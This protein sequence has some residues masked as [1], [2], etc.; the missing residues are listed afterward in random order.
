VKSRTPT[1]QTP[2]IK[3]ERYFEEFY[4]SAPNMFVSVCAKTGKVVQ[5]NAS[6]VT[7][8]GYPKQEIIG[9]SIL[10]RFTPKTIKKTQATYE[11]FQKNGY[12]ENAELILRKKNGGNIPVLVNSK[13][14]RDKE[15]KILYSCS[16]LTDISKLQND[17]ANIQI[18]VNQQKSAK[19][20]LQREKD[21]LQATIDC[22]GE[23]VIITNKQ[24]DFTHF[25][26][27]AE[28]L[29]GIGNSGTTI[30]QWSKDYRIYSSNNQTQ[31][32]SEQEPMYKALQGETTRGVE[33]VL[34]NPETP[35]G[36]SVSATAT[37]IV[38]QDGNVQGSV[39]VFRDITTQKKSEAKSRFFAVM[40]HEL[41]TPLNAI[42]GYS[43]MLDEDL[44][45]LTHKE[46]K[47]DIEKIN[48]AGQHLLKIINDVLDISKIE[49]GKMT[50]DINEFNVGSM[51][52]E[53]EAIIKPLAHKKKLKFSSD[54]SK[55]IINMRSDPTKVRQSLMN[56]LGNAVKYTE[57]GH[58][59]IKA[60]SIKSDDQEKIEFVISDTGC[61][62]KP[63]EINEMTQSFVQG[64]RSPRRKSGGTGLG[65]T[66]T[67][68]FSELLGGELIIES[69]EGKGTKC[70]LRLP[71]FDLSPNGTP[72]SN[73]ANSSD[74][75]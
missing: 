72:H 7:G 16:I 63:H 35:E 21:L 24:G 71:S 1:Q 15:G 5:C 50:L 59:T 47:E 22:I 11:F 13:A 3:P 41:R 68:K 2:G 49:A 66:I 42:I 12:L 46:L 55:S 4:E 31:I 6:F 64:N 54:F 38:D 36:I 57:S 62:I 28:K 40:S 10:T 17:L 25:N 67:K 58:I 30:S 65:L 19:K 51:L 44:E 43:E 9:H 56:L 18:E 34:R 32:P 14:I 74:L 45:S 69:A 26:P 20:E 53:V 23:G 61:G 39:G 73:P 70:I 75:I 27:A 60:H 29:I 8:T 37:P 48:R 33:F 52:A